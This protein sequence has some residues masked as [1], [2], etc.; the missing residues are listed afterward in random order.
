MVVQEVA[1]HCARTTRPWFELRETAVEPLL[2]GTEREWRKR[3]HGA[4]GS[5]CLSE[6][7]C[8][9][10]TQ[11]R[12]DSLGNRVAQARMLMVF[13]MVG[14][15]GWSG[16]LLASLSSLPLC[17]TTVRS[18][19]RRRRSYCASSSSS[20]AF[21]TPSFHIYSIDVERAVLPAWQSPTP[22]DP[23]VRKC[24]SPPFLR[25]TLTKDCPH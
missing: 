11:A 9:L 10:Q 23:T 22:A 3:T 13:M 15:D 21:S 17:P 6:T 2:E 5:S 4:S 8:N 16:W 24:L 7:G 12:R 18:R 19:M 14:T 20:T 25:S 1:L